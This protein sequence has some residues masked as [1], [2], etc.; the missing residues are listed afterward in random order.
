[1]GRGDQS[2]PAGPNCG[3]FC[4]TVQR[5]VSLWQ[6]HT[7]STASGL[8]AY[9]SAPHVGTWP[10]L[11]NC[12][13]GCGSRGCGLQFPRCTVM[14]NH[15]SVSGVVLCSMLGLFCLTLVVA[16][17]GVQ[18]AV[19][20]PS[21]PAA[22]GCC[23]VRFT[24]SAMGLVVVGSGLSARGLAALGCRNVVCIV[25]APV[26]AQEARPCLVVWQWW[27]CTN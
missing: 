12:A 15:T 2:L 1:M 23:Q 26:V 7:Q 14:C 13:E 24:I 4:G 20:V 6:A 16:C 11:F 10:A 19:S 8:Q 25:A 21:R 18:A 5:R 17:Q 22:G 3:V 9:V 27:H